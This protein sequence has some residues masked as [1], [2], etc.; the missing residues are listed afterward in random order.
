MPLMVSLA[1]ASGAGYV[2]VTTLK[3]H[4]SEFDFEK[5]YVKF[6]ESNTMHAASAYV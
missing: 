2:L 1:R 4:K 6:K 5:Y 3:L